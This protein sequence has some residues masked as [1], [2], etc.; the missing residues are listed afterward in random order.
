MHSIPQVN[1]VGP[2]I[3][4]AARIKLQDAYRGAAESL[5]TSHDVMLRLFNTVCGI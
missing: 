5:E 3:D 4:E 2:T 1:G